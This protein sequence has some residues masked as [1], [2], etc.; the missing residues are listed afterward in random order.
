MAK[1][2]LTEEQRAAKAAKTKKAPKVWLDQEHEDVAALAKTA[3][4]VAKENN[5]AGVV[6]FGHDGAAVAGELVD[7]K[8]KNGNLIKDSKGKQV[9][10]NQIHA[11]MGNMVNNK[12]G[13]KTGS[14]YHLPSSSD[15]WA[16]IMQL[17]KAAYPDL[18]EAGN[19]SYSPA[20]KAFL[21]ELLVGSSGGG[22]GAKVMNRDLSSL[23]RTFGG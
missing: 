12:W 21:E 13:S 20:V 7:A 15:R 5:F 17:A 18:K 19:K 9:K 22:G 1:K 4:G 11:N 8:D 6:G 10:I 14:L 2:K 3:V 16:K 23:S